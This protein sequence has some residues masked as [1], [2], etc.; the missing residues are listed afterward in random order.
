MGSNSIET[1]LVKFTDVSALK[2]VVINCT[3]IKM[4]N[5]EINKDVENSISGILNFF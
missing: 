4:V 5:K 1:D 3:G 2:K